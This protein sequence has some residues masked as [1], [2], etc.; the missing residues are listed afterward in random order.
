MRLTLLF[1]LLFTGFS[2]HAQVL[3]GV[4]FD[5][6]GYPI[7]F[8]RVG[9][10]NSTYAT[11]TNGEGKYQLE[12]KPGTHFLQISANTYETLSDTIVMNSD[13]I[14]HDFVLNPQGYELQETVITARSRKDLA[15]EIMQHVIDQRKDWEKAIETYDCNLYAFTG[16]ELEVT[17]SI[18]RDSV[19]SKK[20]MNIAELY[21]HSFVKGGNV[22][23][24]SI[25]GNID[26]SDKARNTGS[27]SVQVSMGDES[28]QTLNAP[29]SNPYLFVQGLK[30]A[31]INL[32]KNQL[33]KEQLSFR[34]LI[35][36][37]AYNALVYYSFNLEGTFFDENKREINKITV[38]PRF[39]EEALYS[40]TLYI[41]NDNFHVLSA[42]LE[43]NKA[44]LSYFKELHLLIDFT[45]DGDKLYPN[46]REYNYVIKE[47]RKKYNGQ[48]RSTVTNYQ[49]EDAQVKPNFWLSEQ[50]DHPNAYDRD[51]LFWVDKRPFTL[52]TEELKFIHEQDSI[53]KYYESEEYLKHA[54][55]TYNTLS[56]WDFLFNGVGFRNTFK[57]QEIFITG[58]IGQVVP[59]G[60]GGY[61]H[62]LSGSYS[63]GL[64]NGMQ[65]DIRPTI[66]YG[67]YNKDLKG[68]VEVDW[69]Y[70]PLRFSKIHL[71]GGDIYDFV[72]NYQSIQGTF[73]PANRVRNQKFEI[74]HSFEVTN[75]L[76]LKTGVFFSNRRNISGI[77]YPSWVEY[78]GSA[79]STPTY[80]DDYSVFVSEIGLE[81]HFRQKYLIQ[82]KQKII[83]ADKWPVVNLTY[84]KG[85]PGLMGGQSD[86][87]FA[88]LRVKDEI[89]LKA[90]GSS[91]FKLTTGTFLRKKDLRLIEYKYFRT[92]DFFFS[93]PLNSQQLLD[94]L[95]STSNSY[96][97]INFIHHFEGFFLNKVWG[98]NR[99]KL[100][101]TIGGSFLGIPDAHFAQA[102]L[103]VGLERKIRIKKQVFK[104]GVYAVTADNSFDSM[105]FTYKFGINFY[106]SFYKK[107]DY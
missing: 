38:I 42:D 88:E 89:N 22:Y 51:S 65:F 71:M 19:I 48:I 67:F 46:R 50:I 1:L 81:Y 93:N 87:D 35:S 41:A 75:G 68:E 57:K 3:K 30:S 76:Y 64:K 94:T 90:L 23:K 96:M 60:V 47:G 44:S 63:K 6:E 98:L 14:Q 70:N 27:V 25:L 28:L 107:W 101:E 39:R 12:L 53:T 55:S 8:A 86:F 73:S 66:D 21:T 36:P 79:F 31:D 54:D 106:D 43:I 102:E 99:L 32:F 85:I 17:D 13:G 58:L 33:D 103:Y 92:S 100:E 11:L 45:E 69:L 105:K 18:E 10:T 77:A 2:I 24:D 83:T 80:F 5:S 56:V 82:R 40:G 16:I 61:R 95:L 59:F 97:Q 72:T 37:L 9:I 52:K 49:F 104:V 91:Q 4:V 29:E 26:L 62:R 34:P 20:K 15:K 84:K 7:P 74:A 78:F